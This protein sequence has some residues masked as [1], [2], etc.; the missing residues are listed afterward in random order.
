[1]LLINSKDQIE[2]DIDYLK[3]EELKTL[4]DVIHRY[5]S[6]NMNLFYHVVSSPTCR[7][8]KKFGKNWLSV[9]ILKMSA[10]ERFVNILKNRKKNME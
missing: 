5:E 1:M 10:E 2:Y 8:E 3:N 4:D 7:Y 9:E 6:S